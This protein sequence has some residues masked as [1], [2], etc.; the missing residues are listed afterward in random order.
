[1]NGDFLWNRHKRSGGRQVVKVGEVTNL[2][3]LCH[4]AVGHKGSNIGTYRKIKQNYYGIPRSL[5]KSFVLKCPYCTNRIT[6]RKSLKKET[7]KRIEVR[8]WLA[9]YQ[10][11]LVDMRSIVKIPAEAVK[12]TPSWVLNKHMIILQFQRDTHSGTGVFDLLQ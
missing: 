9:R 11:D 1:M 3:R 5:V 12:S 4:E 7:P 2:I 6:S 10:F 8:D